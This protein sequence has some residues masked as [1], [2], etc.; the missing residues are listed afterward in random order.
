MR[1]SQVLL[2]KKSPEGLKWV[3]LQDSVNINLVC[4]VD[5]QGNENSKKTVKAKC[6]L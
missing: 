4:C 1:I 3:T 6:C 2:R 5:F